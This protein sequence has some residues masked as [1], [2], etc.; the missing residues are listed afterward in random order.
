M[1]EVYGGTVT[2]TPGGYP[3]ISLNTPLILD[4]NHDGV[5]TLGTD[6]GVCNTISPDQVVWP[7]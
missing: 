7:P 1:G 5:S 6:A 2:G 4:L 3:Q